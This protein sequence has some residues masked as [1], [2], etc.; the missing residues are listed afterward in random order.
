MRR[1]PSRRALS[2]GAALL[3]GCGAAPRAGAPSKPRP[4]EHGSPPGCG[5]PPPGVSIDAA[6]L[7]D[8]MPL[9]RARRAG[10]QMIAACEG[11]GW[12]LV[13]LEARQLTD[14]DGFE[15]DIVR[16]EAVDRTGDGAPELE[17]VYR[18]TESLTAL[19]PTGPYRRGEA[20]MLVAPAPSARV[21]LRFYVS[22]ETDTAVAFGAATMV[23]AGQWVEAS[24]GPMASVVQS[25]AI[26][27]EAPGDD[28]GHGP[29]ETRVE[30]FSATLRWDE[31]RVAFEQDGALWR[32]LIPGL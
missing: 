18:F 8:G 3:L 4:A 20:V 11:A 17:V 24:P 1:P 19:P 30:V 5:Q 10:E 7:A 9:H 23:G 21:L 2:F 29:P 27:E 22:G 16:A 25:V 32:P 14:G 31:A 12:R 13:P 28:E 6:P 26:T 15:A